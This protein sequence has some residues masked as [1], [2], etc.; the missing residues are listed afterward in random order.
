MADDADKWECRLL[1]DTNDKAPLSNVGDDNVEERFRV[2]RRKLELLIQGWSW[3]QFVTHTAVAR[4]RH[5]GAVVSSFL[6]MLP[7]AAM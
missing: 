2:D 5:E 1:S 7:L 4:W 6:E 3:R